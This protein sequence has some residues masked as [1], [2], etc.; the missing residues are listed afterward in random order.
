MFGS[1]DARAEYGGKGFEGSC[2]N[3]HKGKP[4]NQILANFQTPMVPRPSFKGL[5]SDSDTK[6]SF[7]RAKSKK[8]VVTPLLL[9]LVLVL[10]VVGM[11]EI[12]PL[13]IMML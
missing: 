13:M 12:V 6:Q 1:C 7:K 11:V 4:V 5:A 3:G 9:L 10:L 2:K 8:K